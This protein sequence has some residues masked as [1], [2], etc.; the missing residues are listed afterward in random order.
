MSNLQ[1]SLKQVAEH[2]APYEDVRAKL[3]L[4]MC[5]PLYDDTTVPHC[6]TFQHNRPSYILEKLCNDPTFE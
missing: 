5:D 2:N 1:E 4:K 6:I 3:A